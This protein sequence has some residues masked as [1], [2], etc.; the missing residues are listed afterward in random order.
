MNYEEKLQMLDRQIEN[1]EKELQRLRNNRRLT[2][3]NWRGAGV[4][5]AKIARALRISRERVR[6]IIRN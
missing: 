3:R 5:Y 6:Q 4:S 2:I 1:A